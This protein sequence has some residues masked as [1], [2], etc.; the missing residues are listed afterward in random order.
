MEVADSPGERIIGSVSG[1]EFEGSGSPFFK[2][3]DDAR[4]DI[5]FISAGIFWGR[6]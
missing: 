3:L 1:K 2:L 4:G 6:P 5:T